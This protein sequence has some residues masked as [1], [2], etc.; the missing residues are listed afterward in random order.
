MAQLQDLTDEYQERGD[1]FFAGRPAT[2]D[3][4]RSIS[5]ARKSR[6]V[7]VFPGNQGRGR[8]I[9]HINQENMERA[10]REGQAYGDDFANLL[11]AAGLAA[12]TV[13]AALLIWSTTCA[14]LRP[15]QAVTR[16]P[17]P[18]APANSTRRC[19]SCR[20]DEWANWPRLQPH[21]AAACAI[22]VIRITPA[23]CVRSRP[24]RRPSIPSPIPSWWSIR[25]AGSRWPTRRPIA[26]WASL[27]RRPSR[28]R[29]HAW[30][31][32]PALR[33]PVG[34]RLAEA[35]SISDR[36]VRPGRHVPLTMAR[37]APTCRKSSPSAIPLAA[38]SA[39]PWSSPT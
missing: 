30:L 1:R 6:P 7:A 12:T 21:D 24:A 33:Q 18:S 20:D 29:R 31:P 11:W 14:M 26:C 19:R 25:T 22:I 5:G 28:R 23:C 36:G 35:A 32:P 38:P 37:I 3:V 17:S 39:P 2:P 4:R 15:I 8:P 16:R 9:R 34:G 13:L 27:P 10:K